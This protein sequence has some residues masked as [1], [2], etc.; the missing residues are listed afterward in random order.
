[1]TSLVRASITFYVEY[2]K[3]YICCF[4]GVILSPYNCSCFITIFG[5]SLPRV[6]AN[7]VTVRL[8]LG[9]AIRYR[10]LVGRCYPSFTTYRPPTHPP[11]YQI[12]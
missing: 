12:S 5:V 8:A 2:R 4:R 11:A 1:M 6:P 9:L 3:S 7:S 10:E